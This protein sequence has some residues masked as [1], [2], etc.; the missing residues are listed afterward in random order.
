MFCAPMGVRGAE[1]DKQAAVCLLEWSAMPA[2]SATLA[3]LILGPTSLT[4]I[5]VYVCIFN[6]DFYHE[7][8]YWLYL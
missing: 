8:F 2:Y 7:T 4:I 1:Y 3:L 6:G 5:Y